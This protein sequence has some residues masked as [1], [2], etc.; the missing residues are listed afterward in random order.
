MTEVLLKAGLSPNEFNGLVSRGRSPLQ[1]AVEDGNLE[2]IDLLLECGADVNAPA[3][4]DGGAMA[5][6]LAAIQGL[7]GIA[8]RLIDL[9][10][11][12]NAPRADQYG[13]TALEGAA[14]HGRLDMDHLLLDCGASVVGDGFLQYFKAIRFGKIEKHAV[15]AN[16]LKN[17]REW[18]SFDHETW[19]SLI[20]LD[21][22][23][24]EKLGSLE[25]FIDGSANSE[26]TEIPSS[27]HGD[28]DSPE[29]VVWLNDDS[30]YGHDSTWEGSFAE[31]RIRPTEATPGDES[32]GQLEELS[33][34]VLAGIDHDSMIVEDQMFSYIYD[35]T[36]WNQRLGHAENEVQT[37]WTSAP[38]KLS[39][40]STRWG[41]FKAQTSTLSRS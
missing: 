8:R 27:S 32:L 38:S 31:G 20:A 24:L 1:R 30:V 2:M 36:A 13:R 11:N 3:A 26:E 16:F 18:S 17:H 6:Q 7:L 21:K 14:E 29:E 4:H 10:A 28:G 41:A 35:G 22:K 15:V 37:S 5:L 12:V 19:G 9:G 34:A 39:L 33:E 40:A 25:E 23:R